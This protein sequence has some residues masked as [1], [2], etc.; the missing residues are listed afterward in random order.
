[1][2]ERQPQP[3]RLTDD[4]RIKIGVLEAWE[5]KRT[6]DDLTARIIASQWHGGQRSSLYSF[7]STGAIHIEGLLPEIVECHHERTTRTQLH[8]LDALTEYFGERGERGPVEEWN[9]TNN[10]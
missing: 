10:W 1:M 7:V 9:S 3:E 5:E 8:I 6:I 2:M 4:E